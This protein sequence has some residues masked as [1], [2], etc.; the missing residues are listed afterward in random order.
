MTADVLDSK[1]LFTMQL[2][3]TSFEEALRV[4]VS[5]SDVE[6]VTAWTLLV[7]RARLHGKI[8]TVCDTYSY[9]WRY[10]DLDFEKDYKQ[11]R[12]KLSENQDNYMAVKLIQK[13]EQRYELAS[14]K[15]SDN[16]LSQLVKQFVENLNQIVNLTEKYEQALKQE[17]Q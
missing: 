14:N 7:V 13:L 16:Y 11:L 5:D 9:P 10:L 17:N 1:Q 2:I 4:S 15:M 3:E 12:T 8:N 6:A